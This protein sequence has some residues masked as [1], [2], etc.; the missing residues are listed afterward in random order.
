MEIT[1]RRHSSRSLSPAEGSSRAPTLQSKEFP[2]QLHSP[3][4]CFTPLAATSGSQCSSVHSLMPLQKR[5][6]T[7]QCQAHQLPCI[8]RPASCR[9][10][11]ALLR[12]L[13]L[14]AAALGRGSASGGS[15]GDFAK[16]RCS[17]S[18]T[19]ALPEVR[20]SRPFSVCSVFPAVFFVSLCHF[21]FYF[22]NA[23]FPSASKANTLRTGQHN[24]RGAKQKKKTLYF[25]HAV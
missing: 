3:C 19:K 10:P 24:L 22:F 14:V 16:G 13:S 5:L 20:S 15:L 18:V 25:S 12:P 8:R 21:I 6:A 1:K 2:Q 11:E 17:F 7:A 9:W 23:P 4:R